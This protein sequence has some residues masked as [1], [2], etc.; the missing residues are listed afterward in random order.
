VVVDGRFSLE[1]I[2][3]MLNAI[4][5]GVVKNIMSATTNY[6]GDELFGDAAT[7]YQEFLSFL[8]QSP[9]SSP[10]FTL[11]AVVTVEYQMDID[12]ENVQETV[13]LH[14]SS[15][16]IQGCAKEWW[17]TYV[18]QPVNRFLLRFGAADVVFIAYVWS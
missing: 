2:V 16:V 3:Y 5:T 13:I 7:F 10:P 6:Y 15:A 11:H 9:R 17:E 18:L 4:Q 1:N 14:T 12:G 8:E